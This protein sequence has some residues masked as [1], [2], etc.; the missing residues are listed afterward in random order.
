MAGQSG[1]TPSNIDEI[2]FWEIQGDE[3]EGEGGVT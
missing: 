3:N 1:A 2:H